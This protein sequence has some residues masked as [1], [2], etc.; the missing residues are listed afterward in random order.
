MNEIQVLA[1]VYKI[2]AESSE[3]TLSRLVRKKTHPR[4]I[5]DVVRALRRAKKVLAAEKRD[6]QSKEGRGQEGRVTSSERGDVQSSW[7]PQSKRLWRSM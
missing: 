6:A 1:S 7:S 3:E 5:L 4:M 2:L